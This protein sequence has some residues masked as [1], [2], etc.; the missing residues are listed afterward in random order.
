VDSE[1]LHNSYSLIE[2]IYMIHLY[3]YHEEKVDL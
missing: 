2:I 1:L 3:N